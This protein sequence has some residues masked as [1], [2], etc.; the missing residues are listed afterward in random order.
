MRQLALL[1]LLFTSFTQNTYANYLWGFG[2]IS[3][4]YLDW[5][6]ATENKDALKRDFS[7]VE[8]EGG[9]QFDWGDLYGFFDLERWNDAGIDQRTAS[10]GIMNYYIGETPFSVYGHVYSFHSDGFSDQSRVVGLGYR[11]MKKNFFFKPFLGFHNTV[12]TFYT[13]SNGY[14]TGWFMMYMFSLAEQKFRIVSWHET[15]FG[16]D[17]SY[18]SG[19]GNKSHSLNGAISLWWDFTHKVNFGVQYRYAEDKLGTAG[20]MKA[21]IFSLRYNLY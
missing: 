15:E 5:D 1:L 12:Q 8:I 14:M 17:P 11:L 9:A 18:A 13:G 7:Y 2:D 10:K 4:N 21:A 16:R 19:N 3:M 20:A 6:T